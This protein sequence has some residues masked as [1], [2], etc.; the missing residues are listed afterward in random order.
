[1]P[2]DCYESATKKVPN[3]ATYLY[4][5]GMVELANGDKRTARSEL[6]AALKLKLAGDDAVR[7]QQTL[8]QIG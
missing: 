3:N 7:T 4:H 8:Q 6:K 5:L 1:M 2:S